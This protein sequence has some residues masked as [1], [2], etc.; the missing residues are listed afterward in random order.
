MVAKNAKVVAP[1]RRRLTDLYVLGKEVSFSDG[2]EGEEPIVVWLSKL[3]PIEQRDA[4][5][6]ATGAR[7]KILSLR[8]KDKSDATERQLA[9]YEEQLE[10]L[11]ISDKDSMIE[12]LISTKLQQALQSNEN[13]IGS[14]GEW[15]ENNYLDALQKAW[16]DGIYEEYAKDSNEENDEAQRI[17]K[18]LLR[19]SEE[20]QAAT[21]EDKVNLVAEYEFST[22]EELHKLVL[23]RTI[24]AEAD[25]AWVNEFSRW[26]AFYAVRFA[27]EHKVRY[28][29]DREEVD[30]L[31]P[32]ILN[33]ILSEY[34]AMTVETTE[35][36]D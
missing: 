4:A 35:G 13:R 6:N 23:D 11:G 2:A 33:Q 25:F 7:A 32:K 20:V 15:A 1:T 28:F 21:E 8:S 31:D 10:D 26:Q 22:D 12:Y 24:E 14:E 30:A 3:S 34:T 36:K 18:E 29:E 16:N 9:V 27:E 5:D 19:F 17:Y